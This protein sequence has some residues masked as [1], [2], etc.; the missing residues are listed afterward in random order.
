MVCLD[1]LKVLVYTILNILISKIVLWMLHIIGKKDSLG[2][3]HK[4]RVSQW[5]QHVLSRVRC[6]SSCTQLNV[7]Q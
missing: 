4:E 5:P 1:S 3:R 2:H 6:Q 7:T